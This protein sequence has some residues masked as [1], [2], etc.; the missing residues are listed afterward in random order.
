MGEAFEQNSRKR[1]G[2][3][4]C[5]MREWLDFS[6]TCYDIGAQMNLISQYLKRHM[7]HAYHC[8]H[9]MQVILMIVSAPV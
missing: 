4:G 6:D 9:G 1:T 7:R 3:E 2:R 8:Q 5:M